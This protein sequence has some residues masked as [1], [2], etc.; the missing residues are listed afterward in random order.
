ML[1]VSQTP[2]RPT[3][4]PAGPAGTAMVCTT[5]C[6]AGLIRETVE[7]PLFVTQTEPAPTAMPGRIG[8]DRNRVHDRPRVG[9]DLYDR[10]GSGNVTQTPPSPIATAPGREPSGTDP[11]ERRARGR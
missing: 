2:S 1:F 9:V 10:P 6:V 5:A 4:I 7:L 8:S 3:V 11:S